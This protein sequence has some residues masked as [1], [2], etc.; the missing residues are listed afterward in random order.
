MKPGAP[1]L[2]VMFLEPISRAS[3]LPKP[4]SPAL[5]AKIRKQLEKTYGPEYA[6]FLNLMAQIREQLLNGENTD[7]ADRKI[8][9]QNMLHDDILQWIK[10]GRK[11]L[12]EKH[13]HKVF[14]PGANFDFFED[15][16][17]SDR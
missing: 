10:D 8:L 7:C 1:V 11:E 16:I 13:L 9:F 3:D 4:T 12:L 17:R 2:T 6:V 15:L 14:G 5:A